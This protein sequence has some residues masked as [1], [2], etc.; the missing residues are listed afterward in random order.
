VKMYT[1]YFTPFPDH[2]AVDVA[3][4]NDGEEGREGKEGKKEPQT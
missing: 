3:S 1:Y 4:W 2:P